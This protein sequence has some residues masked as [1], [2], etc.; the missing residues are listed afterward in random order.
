MQA[1]WGAQRVGG[2]NAA[3]L[4]FVR[5]SRYPKTLSAERPIRDAL[6]VTDSVPGQT[7]QFSLFSVTRFSGCVLGVKLHGFRPC[8]FRAPIWV[9]P[10]PPRLISGTR[11]PNVDLVGTYVECVPVYVRSH[12]LCAQSEFDLCV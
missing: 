4:S 3:G 2:D 10:A 1:A 5:S 8:H 7:P 9:T 11:L 6:A 12:N